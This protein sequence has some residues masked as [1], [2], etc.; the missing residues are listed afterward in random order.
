MK[1]FELLGRTVAREIFTIKEQGTIVER[2]QHLIEQ[3]HPGATKMK[4]IILGSEQSV[5][6]IPYDQSNRAPHGFLHGGC[7][8]SVG[9]TLTAIMSEYFL[10]NPS[11]RTLTMEGSIRYLRPVSR[12][13]VRVKA[14]L[15]S[16]NG[17][18]LNFVCDFF[19]EENKRVA[20][21]KYRYALTSPL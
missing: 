2:T 4:L 20:Q 6:E 14:R 17:K 1:A 7:M 19:N 15:L 8:Y 13:T 18:I 10:E 21:A 9:D 16:R 11:E 5:A 12:E 3:C